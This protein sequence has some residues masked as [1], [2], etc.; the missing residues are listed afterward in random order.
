[1]NLHIILKLVTIVKNSVIQF[2]ERFT[3][4]THSQDTDILNRIKMTEKQM[5]SVLKFGLILPHTG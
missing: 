2:W 1:M 4:F 3:L 5:I